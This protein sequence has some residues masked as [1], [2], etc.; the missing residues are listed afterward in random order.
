MKCQKTIHYKGYYRRHSEAV[1]S[2]QYDVT[3][4]CLRC[5]PG[6]PYIMFA[7]LYIH[8]KAAGADQP[9]NEQL[10]QPGSMQ[11]ADR[12]IIFTGSLQHGNDA[13]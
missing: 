10:Q 11:G 5:T 6:V 9:M 2:T 12:I 8:I 4:A 3:L 1:G 13:E 7:S